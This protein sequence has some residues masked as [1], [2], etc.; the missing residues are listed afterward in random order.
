MQNYTGWHKSSYSG[1]GENCVVQG[2]AQTEGAVQEVGVIDSKRTDSPILSFGPAAW[3]SFVGD[4][5]GSDRSTNTL[6]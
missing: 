4:V 3:L 5:K 2:V 6:A 1:G